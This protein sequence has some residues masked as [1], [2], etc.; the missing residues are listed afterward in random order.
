MPV[1][2][3]FDPKRPLIAARAFLFLGVNYAP[4]DPFNP[5]GA[6]DRQRAAQ[7]ESRAVNFAPEQ[8]PDPVRMEPAPKNGSWLI[9]AP[10]F[11]E[12]ETV[13]GKVNAEARLAEVLEDGPPLE[14]MAAQIAAQHG[15]PEGQP[16]APGAPEGAEAGQS[17]DE[18]TD[19]NPAK[20]ET[21]NAA[22]A[23]EGEEKPPHTPDGA[24]GAQSGA[25]ADQ[26]VSADP[27][28]LVA[29]SHT[30]GGYYDVTAPWL[31]EPQQVRGKANAEK[32]RDALKE[33]GPPEGWTPAAA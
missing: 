18:G 16:G 7:Y 12:P 33:A 2:P 6:S 5:E 13:R 27:R 8:A 21:E 3:R 29:L 26:A 1:R 31:S 32:A 22:A 24:E 20:P 25:E 11:A 23:A 4:G 28:A 15:E 30:G 14:W 9:I 10:W 17:A 19:T